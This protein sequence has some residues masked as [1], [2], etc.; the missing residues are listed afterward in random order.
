MTP[1][2][3]KVRPATASDLP[4]IVAML[5]DDPLGAERERFADPLPDRYHAAFEAIEQDSNNELLVVEG[6]EG[7]I[8]AVMQITFTPYITHQGGWRATIEG[9]RVDRRYRGS[10]VGRELF[11]W[12][13]RRAQER[14]C[15]LVQLTTDKKRP[16]ALRFYEALGFVASH[17]GMKLKLGEHSGND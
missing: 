10:G 15:H 14:G 12:A 17:E 11:A 8:L 5:A 1:A 13:I 6:E 7:D 9:V 16:E 3:F 2:S 4:R